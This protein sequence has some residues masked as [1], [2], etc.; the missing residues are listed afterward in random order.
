MNKE[1][2]GFIIKGNAF[3][4]NDQMILKFFG[5]CSEG[6]FTLEL[7]NFSNYFFVDSTQETSLRNTNFLNVEKIES[8]S[9]KQRKILKESYEFNHKRTYELDV[10]PIERFLMD[11]EIYGSVKIIGD[12]EYANGVMNFKNPK[13]FSHPYYPTFKIYSFDIETAKDGRILSIASHVNF[14]DKDDFHT[15]ILSDEKLIS[16]EFPIQTFK[17]E[18]EM[19][20]K[21][22]ADLIKVDPDIIIGWNV[23][24]FDL[25]YIFDRCQKLGCRFSIGREKFDSKIFQSAR[26]DYIADISGRVVIDGPW[27]LKMNFFSF[28]SFKLNE[29][30][31]KILGETKDID[32]DEVFD[33]WS[34]IERRFKEDKLALLRYNLKDAV[35]VTKIFQKTGL[36][37][38]F[39]NRSLISGMLLEKVGGSTAAFDHFFLPKFH[40]FGFVAPNVLDVGWESEAKGGFVLNPIIGI[41]DNVIVLDFKSL[42]PTLI[43]TFTID[44]LSRLKRDC[45]PIKTPVG[46]TFSQTENILPKKIASLLELR[47]KAKK[48][49]NEN[50]SMAIKILMNSFYGVMGSSGCR[51]YHSE[52]PDAITGTGQ[53]ILKTTIG[54]LESLG[55]QILYGDTDSIFVKVPTFEGIFDQGTKLV[56]M[57]NNFLKE[58]LSQDFQVESFME[59]QFDKVFKKLIL[60]STRSQSEG[61]KKRYAGL[62]IKNNNS[63]LVEEIVLTGMEFVRSDWSQLAK[64][65]QFELV[66]RIF[67]GLDYKEFVLET[68]KKLENGE[69]DHQL[70]L[71]KRLTKPIEEYVLN[72]PPHV[73]ALRVLFEKTGIRKN[74]SEFVMTRRGP[75]PIELKPTDFDYNY[76]LEKQLSPVA[77]SILHLLG[78]DFDKL[79]NVQLSLF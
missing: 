18:K 7:D 19:L 1:I 47:A 5:R 8:K 60:T 61:A 16:D 31:K 14:E 62:L 29:V 71:K 4:H 74:R 41:H 35:L 22:Q 9:L 75:M 69:L 42:Y 66:R 52:L 11:N 12:Y 6:P 53:W 45:R 79:R 68:I 25:K 65:F 51:F 20:V 38:L 56:Q 55:F 67:S 40:E 44:P 2:D 59:I 23:V 26:G 58:K 36:I 27:S 57:I 54:Y 28:E 77:N 49:K 70:V 64:N 48:E 34:E 50:L 43:R 63:I 17:S 33:K 15:Y 24:G 78:E 73:K 30:A 39:I 37:D 13:I 21:F 46:I 3:D 72:V 10:R 32:E 76:Y